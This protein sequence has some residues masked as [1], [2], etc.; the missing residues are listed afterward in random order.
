MAINRVPNLIMKEVT[1]LFADK[2]NCRTPCHVF[3]CHQIR[4]GPF[5]LLCIILPWVQTL[6]KV[7]GYSKESLNVM[8]V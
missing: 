2:L 7:A 4:V 3:A 5:V 8:L 1:G 6:A